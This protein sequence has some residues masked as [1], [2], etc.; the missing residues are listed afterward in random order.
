MSDRWDEMFKRQARQQETFN[1]DPSAM[2]PMDRARV[3]KDLALGMFEEA[4]ELMRVATH[5]KA[6]VL[7]SRPVEQVNLADEAADVLKYLIAIAQLYG[8]DSDG[9]YDS[10]MRKSAVV[11][12][13]ARGE[14]LA[15][16]TST[17]LVVIDVDNCLADLSEWQ[18]KLNSAQGG[19]PMNDRT[20]ALLESLKE[21]FYR[22]GQFRELP[23]IRGASEATQAIR[24]LGFKI[25]LMTARPYAQYKNLYADTMFWLREHGMAYD[26]ILFGKDKAEL[27]YEHIFPAR[28]T[29]FVEDRVKH[30]LEVASIGVPVLLLDWPYN[31]ELK[32]TRLI[33]RVSDWPA[34][35]KRAAEAIEGNRDEHHRD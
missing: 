16:E 31:R 1:L 20:I 2:S 22:G 28:P 21:D 11:D 12:D 15:L 27:I 35:V 25:V 8:V 23:P 13:R 32:D 19:A 6:H 7:R 14:R 17:R 9:L 34:I 5:F 30:C 3:S 10:F 24:D 29:F 4:A 33:Q 18:D 26:L